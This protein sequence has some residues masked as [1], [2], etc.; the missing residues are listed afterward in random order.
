[1]ELP[2]GAPEAAITTT[3][4]T[5]PSGGATM[6][7]VTAVLKNMLTLTV[8]NAPVVTGVPPVQLTKISPTNSATPPCR[9]V[10]AAGGVAVHVMFCARAGTERPN[11]TVP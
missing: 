5:P 3:P 11:A 10:A 8:G 2:E 9:T 6:R 1:M 7:L 4:D